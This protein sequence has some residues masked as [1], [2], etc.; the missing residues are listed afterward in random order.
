MNTKDIQMKSKYCVYIHTVPKEISGNNND[1]RYIGITCKNNPEKRWENGYGYR[2]NKHFFRA[3]EKYGWDNIKHEVV[4]RELDH[5][6]ACDMEKLLVALY[7]AK[8]PQFGYNKTFGGDGSCGC[9]K[10]EEEKRIR[11]E[12]FKGKNNP[13]Y[14]KKHTEETRR[15]MSLNHCD[16]SG[17]KNYKSKKV[18]QFD[19]NG[20]F[21]KS[22]ACIKQ[23]VNDNNMTDMCVISS[24]REKRQGGIY[25]WGYENDVEKQN[26]VITLK[27]FSSYR[28]NI[29]PEKTIEQYDSEWNYIGVYINI[30]NVAKSFNGTRQNIT[31][32]IKSKGL[33]YGYHWKYKED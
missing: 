6:S 18:Y 14:H 3:I 22:Y 26:G 10:S 16:C 24:I 25:F 19:E 15:K 2:K 28:K 23:A 1:K 33:A 4:A 8:N 31:R 32:A 21:I 30:T 11:S 12:R 27:D 13:F 7:N 5:D 20:T 9:K 29:H 17:E